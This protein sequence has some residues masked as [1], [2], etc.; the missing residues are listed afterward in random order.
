MS[1][2]RCSIS[3]CEAP[4]LARGWCSKHYHRW[5]ANGDPT[6]VR[7]HW[8]EDRSARMKVCNGCRREL[9]VEN[10]Y[11]R[12]ETG[13]PVSRCKDCLQAIRATRSNR[14]VRAKNLKR[15]NISPEQFTEILAAQNGR[16]AICRDSEFSDS[17]SRSLAV[18]HDHETGII[19]GLLCSRC[20]AG[21]GMFRD[22]PALLQAAGAYLQS[23]SGSS[24][25]S[26]TAENSVNTEVR[27]AHLSLMGST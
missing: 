9:P 24:V 5:R 20:N 2:A 14:V 1:A 16:C 17:L 10:F 23:S 21:L 3:D 18:D 12:S 11:K 6:T 4:V 27:G 13:R 8:G 22:D 19:R 25:G 7:S 26:R 15:Y